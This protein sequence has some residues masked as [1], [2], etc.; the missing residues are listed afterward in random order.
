M[1]QAARW[2]CVLEWSHNASLTSVYCFICY[3]VTVW[4]LLIN[5]SWKL[6][7]SFCNG[8][9]Y[10]NLL[11]MLAIVRGVHLWIH[12]M[13]FLALHASCTSVYCLE[14]YMIWDSDQS[15]A[16]LWLTHCRCCTLISRAGHPLL[17]HCYTHLTHWGW[18]KMAAILQRTFSNEFSLMKMHEFR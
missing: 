16:A 11:T 5:N 10:I 14:F 1:D 9:V 3:G 8:S 17:K 7:T 6:P 13:S 12:N 15:Q 18:D 4:I 2:G